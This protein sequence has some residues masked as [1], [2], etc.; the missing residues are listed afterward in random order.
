MSHQNQQKQIL[1]KDIKVQ[2]L[3]N[4]DTLR[5]Y[6]HIKLRKC[7]LPFGLESFVILFSIKLKNWNIWH[8][9]FITVY[10]HEK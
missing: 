9:N 5:N 10:G 2:G 1:W 6:D 8:C 3:E 4:G 7:L